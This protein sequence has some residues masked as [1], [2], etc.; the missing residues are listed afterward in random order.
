MLVPTRDPV[1]VPGPLTNTM[2]PT[3]SSVH[4]ASTSTWSTAATTVLD[5]VP[6]C[7]EVCAS[8]SFPR[9]RPTIP[10]TVAVLMRR[11]A[12]FDTETPRNDGRL[13]AV[14]YTHL[15]AHETRHDLVCRLLLEKKK[16]KK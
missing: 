14:S 1:K 12:C 11:N 6:N 15:R 2:L 8:T 9:A 4:P 7:S 10:E 16:K 13:V 3:S 5:A